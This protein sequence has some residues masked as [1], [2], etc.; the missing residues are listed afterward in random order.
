[1]QKRNLI[2]EKVK[3]TQSINILFN[4]ERGGEAKTNQNL[5]TKN[6]NHLISE[7]IRHKR[8]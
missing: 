5:K 1:M 8:K 4:A 2:L 3:V 7:S 6:K